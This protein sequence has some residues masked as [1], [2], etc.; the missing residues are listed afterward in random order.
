M[1]G[2][3]KG[4]VLRSDE[5]PDLEFGISWL[6]TMLTCPYCAHT[7]EVIDEYT[8]GSFECEECEAEFRVR[9]ASNIEPCVSLRKRSFLERLHNLRANLSSKIGNS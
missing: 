4:L 3:E 9:N 8:S 1:T 5:K 2:K 7:S 6:V